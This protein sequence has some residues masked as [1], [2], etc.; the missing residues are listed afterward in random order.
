MHLVFVAKRNETST[1][2]GKSKYESEKFAILNF[3]F[4]NSYHT[5]EEGIYYVYTI[6]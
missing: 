4:G 1:M 3:F 2:L 6:Q 5:S